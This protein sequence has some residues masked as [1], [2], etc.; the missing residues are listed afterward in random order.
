MAISALATFSLCDSNTTARGVDGAEIRTDDASGLA[1][2]LP[3]NLQTRESDALP[4]RLPSLT[5]IESPRPVASIANVR[6]TT[7]D[8]IADEV[9]PSLSNPLVPF[10]QRLT[11]WVNHRSPMIGLVWLTG[12]FATLIRPAVGWQAMRR[13]PRRGSVFL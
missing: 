6:S 3:A 2:E 4:M 1:V 5:P 13:I 12:F 8:D 7:S 9:T 11:D 10:A